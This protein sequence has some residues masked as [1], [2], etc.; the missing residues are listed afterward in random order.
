MVDRH[1][2]IKRPLSKLSNSLKRFVLFVRVMSMEVVIL[3]WSQ[4]GLFLRHERAKV[5]VKSFSGVLLSY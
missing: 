3:V 5:C 4:V 2:I 1:V